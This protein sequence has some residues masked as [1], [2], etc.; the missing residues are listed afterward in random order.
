MYLRNTSQSRPTKRAN[1]QRHKGTKSCPFAPPS[2]FGLGEDSR[3][4]YTLAAKVI[5]SLAIPAFPVATRPHAKYSPPVRRIW[6]PLL[7]LLCAGAAGCVERR[8]MIRSN[9]P[10]ASVYVDGYEIGTTPI[11]TDFIYYGTRQIKLVKD[12]YETL[13]VNQPIPA[14]WYEYPGVDFVSE[15]V[16]PGNLRDV[17]TLTYQLSPQ[18][19]APVDQLRARA[20]QLRQSAP[21]PATPPPGYGGCPPPGNPNVPAMPSPAGPGNYPPQGPGMPSAAPDGF[22][23]QPVRPLP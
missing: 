21:R 2:H 14:P 7:A 4:H 6:I 15:N 8:M 11:A 23:G 12:G 10:G 16:V 18:L 19:M 9:P 17:R 20:E 22:G 13:T 3:D 1:G 5:S